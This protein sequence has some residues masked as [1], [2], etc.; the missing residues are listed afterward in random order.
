[1][2]YRYRSLGIRKLPNG[3]VRAE[4]AIIERELNAVEQRFVFCSTYAEMNDPMEGLYASSQKVRERSD[5]SD[6]VRDV[7]YEKLGIASFSET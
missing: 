5:Y 2:L 3:K 6:F 1:L 4:R 7:R